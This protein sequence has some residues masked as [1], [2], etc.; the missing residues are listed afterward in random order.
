LPFVP[1]QAEPA[2]HLFVI[3]H[4]DRDRLQRALAEE[5]VGT[6]IHYPVPPHR[7]PAYAELGLGEGRFPIT[8]AIHRE[9][10][11]LPLWPGMTD[12]Q[13]DTVIDAVRRHA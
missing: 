2:W 11:S 13:V 10:L 12:A 7:Q 4:P 9:V 5:G 8:E 6:L 3:R 1:A